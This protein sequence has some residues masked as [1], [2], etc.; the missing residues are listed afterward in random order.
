[1]DRKVTM[2]YA[3]FDQFWDE[4]LGEHWYLDEDDAGSPFWEG[5]DPSRVGTF[6]CATIAWGG[7]GKPSPTEW[8]TQREL[9]EWPDF[10]ALVDRWRS[11]RKVASVAAEIP[12]DKVAEFRAFVASVGGTTLAPRED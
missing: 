12:V 7:D 5:E 9:D 11:K 6:T 1:M 10:F 8:L 4:V 2:T 3:E